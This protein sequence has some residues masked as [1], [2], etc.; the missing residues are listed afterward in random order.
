MLNV[1]HFQNIFEGIEKNVWDKHFRA[2]LGRIGDNPPALK[3]L[4]ETK[5]YF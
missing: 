5:K 4:I 3:F 2:Y 1:K